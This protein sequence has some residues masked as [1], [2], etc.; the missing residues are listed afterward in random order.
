[1]QAPKAAKGQQRDRGHPPIQIEEDAERDHR[2]Y[3]TANQLHQSGADEISDA[4]R[5]PS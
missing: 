1:M 4:L 2:R 5:H 3:Q